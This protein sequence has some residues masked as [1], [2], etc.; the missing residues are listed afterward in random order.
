MS[1]QSAA[2]GSGPGV[3]ATTL[4][5]L[6]FQAGAEK[7]TQAAA[8]LEQLC[9]TYWYPLYAYV[10][11]QGHSPENAQDLTQEFFAQM[12]DGKSIRFADQRRGRFRTFLLTALKNFLI[13]EWKKANREKRGGGRQIVSLDAQQTE[14]RFLSEA[15]DGRTPDKAFD[16]RWAMILLERVLDRIEQEYSALGRGDA[17]AELK[18]SLTG[19]QNDSSYGEIGRR[20]GMSE[21]NVKITVHRLRQRYR[22]VLKEGIRETVDSSEAVDEEM[23]DLMA[24]LSD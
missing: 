1:N 23:R 11:R 10:R 12:L 16:R 13:N 21:A 6:V 7:T 9:G 5:P 20:L 3:F 8:A 17:F 14:S 22:E 24:A 18:S 4:W 19:E 2:A 15:T